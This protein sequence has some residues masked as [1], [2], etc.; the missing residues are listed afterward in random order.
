MA[1]NIIAGITNLA[2][3]IASNVSTYEMRKI[4]DKV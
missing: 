1:Q 2:S 4:A 3:N